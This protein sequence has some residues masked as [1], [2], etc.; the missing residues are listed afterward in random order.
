MMAFASDAPLFDPV[1]IEKLRQVAGEDDNTFVAEI[2]AVFLEEAT[3]SIEGL[4]L[5]CETGDWQTVSRLAHSVKSSAA[6]LGLM[7]LSD[8][9][10]ALEFDTRKAA[11]SGDTS[12]LVAVVR[13]QFEL[14]LPTLKGLS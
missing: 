11:S 1:A 4:K 3:Q 9:C 13:D 6:T 5:G 2:A 14:A 12:S 7:R 10:K 8:A